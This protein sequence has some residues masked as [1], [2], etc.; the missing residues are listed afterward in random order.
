MTD[1]E[2]PKRRQSLL[3]EIRQMRRDADEGREPEL[4]AARM[5]TRRFSAAAIL[6]RIVD[7]FINE[8]GG[9]S[10]ALRDAT[11]E[12]ER[13]K[14]ILATVDYVLAVESIQLSN[15]EKAK[16]IRRTYTELFTYGPLDAL[17][18]DPTITTISIEGADKLAIRREQGELEALPPQFD[19]E[20]HLRAVIRRLLLDSGAEFTE[21]NP[22]IETGLVVNGRRI[23]VNVAGPPVTYKVSVD[24]RLHPAHIV[25]IDS[26]V[27]AGTLNPE[28]AQIITAIALS[29]HGFIIVG[30]PQSGKTTLLNAVLQSLPPDRQAGVT[31]VERAGELNL[32]DAIQRFQVEWPTAD[33]T[34][35]TFGEGIHTALNDE[36]VTVMALDEVRADEAAAIGPLLDQDSPPRQI[37]AVRGPY[38]STR[39]I[40]ALGMLARRSSGQADSEALVQAMYRLVPFVITVRRRKN[41]LQLHSIAE[42]QFREGEAYPDYVELMAMGWIEEVITTGK[43]P[44]LPLD[45]DD[46]IWEPPNADE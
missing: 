35:R 24:I 8:H 39:L 42:W 40:S 30:E 19:S 25:G 46:S 41:R 33:R 38:S 14:L 18:A 9:G 10:D 44:K 17:F 12:T 11:T 36:A 45:L 5:G 31:A 13:L 34:G 37:W 29:E 4:I 7:Q 23:S 26:L 6:E 32:P 16:L 20:S 1:D 3:D 2:T 21:E 27:A 15:D 43:R 22:I 28:A